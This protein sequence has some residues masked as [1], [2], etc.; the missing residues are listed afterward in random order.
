MDFHTHCSADRLSEPAM[1][2]LRRGTEIF[3]ADGRFRT[4]VKYRL[5]SKIV[6]L[7]T[8]RWDKSSGSRWISRNPEYGV[9]LQTHRLRGGGSCLWWCWFYAE[10]PGK[11]GQVLDEFLNVPGPA[12]LQAVVDPFGPPLHQR[13]RPIRRS[14]CGIPGAAEPN[15]SKIALTAI[16]DK[17][18]ELVRGTRFGGSLLNFPPCHFFLARFAPF[19][20]RIIIRV[21]S[22][23]LRP[24]RFR[25]MTQVDADASPRRR[26]A[27]H[28]VNQDIVN[29]QMIGHLRIFFFPPFQ[30]ASALLYRE[31]SHNNEGHLHPRLLYLRIWRARVPTRG[32]RHPSCE[33]AVAR[34]RPQ[35][36]RLRPSPRDRVISPTNRVRHPCRHA[37]RPI[38]AKR[39]GIVNIVSR[40]GH[41]QGPR[42]P[43]KRAETRAS[44]VGVPNTQSRLF[45]IPGILVVVEEHTMA[46]FLPPF[47]TGERGRTP[48]NCARQCDGSAAAPSAKVQRDSIRHIEV[49]AARAAGFRPS[50]R[51]PCPPE[52]F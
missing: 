31:S 32:L 7:R 16:A 41:S 3:D 49:H 11:C 1:R 27:P 28:R 50:A 25:H 47:R 8:T 43:V 10:D 36:P 38:F 29:R 37:D 24:Q 21:G 9:E 51:S 46:L 35:D 13:L 17:V 39:S 18:R 48:F 30:A 45:P 12:L 6:S 2:C 42:L 15:R 5:S 52:S 20:G 23:L 44:E 26:S 4:A 34:V 14:S 40:P 33:S 19:A 22:L